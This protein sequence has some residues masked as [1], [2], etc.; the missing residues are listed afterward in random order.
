MHTDVIGKTSAPALTVWLLTDD[1]PGHRNQLQGLVDALDRHQTISTHW[2]SVSNTRSSW[3][4]ALR[5]Q[6]NHVGD[7]PDL[8]VG[9]GHRTHR[10]LLAVKRHYRAFTAVLMKPSLPISW[11]D[12]AIIPKHDIKRGSPGNTLLTEG[13]INTVI[14]TSGEQRRVDSGLILVGGE[15]KHF[16]W[17]SDAV[18]SQIQGLMEHY[19]AISWQL[20]N[21]R[22]TPAGFIAALTKLSPKLTLHP[23]QET[24]STWVATQLSQ[25]SVVWVTPDS[26]SMVYEALTAGLPVGLFDLPV[27]RQGRVVEGIEQLRRHNVVNNYSMIEGGHT[28]SAPPHQLWEA[29]RAASWLLERLAN[30]QQGR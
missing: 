29:E 30:W 4:Q 17:R 26:V 16:H 15:S 19:P 14:P 21:S 12:A 28:L 23:Y 22:R 20:T 25:A 18:V 7:T 13:V 1:K 11:F 3:W 6:S 10:E 2:I 27:R 8:V 24:P 5:G 9:A